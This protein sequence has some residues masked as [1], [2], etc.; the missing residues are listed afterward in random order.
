ME[1]GRRAKIGLVV[2]VLENGIA[3]RADL[4]KHA[5]VVIDSLRDISIVGE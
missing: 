4:E 1:M 3:Q 2:G 5:D